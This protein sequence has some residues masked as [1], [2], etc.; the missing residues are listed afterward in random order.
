[1]VRKRTRR[2][3]RTLGVQRPHTRPQR[4]HASRKRRRR[5]K[6][7]HL[8]TPPR[9]SLATRPSARAAVSPLAGITAKALL[10]AERAG[11]PAVTKVRQDMPPVLRTQTNLTARQPSEL[12]RRAMDRDVPR[13][14]NATPA[15]PATGSHHAGDAV[16]SAGEG[17][18]RRGRRRPPSGTAAPPPQ[19]TSPKTTPPGREPRRAVTAIGRVDDMQEHVCQGEPDPVNEEQPL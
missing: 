10:E 11:D 3:T 12:P 6:A 17:V 19:P 1:M 16:G 7:E 15:L 2:F 14:M 8:L 18:L 4:G 13:A 9:L 5:R